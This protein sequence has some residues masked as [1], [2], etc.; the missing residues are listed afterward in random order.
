M[1]FTVLTDDTVKKRGLYA[2]HGLSLLI[3]SKGRGILFDTGQS[4]VYIKNAK[5]LGLSLDELD[6]IVLSH[7]HYDHCGGIKHLPNQKKEPEIFL[8][9]SAAAQKYAVNPDGKTH[10]EIGIPWSVKDYN[11]TLIDGCK[12]IDKD[13]SLLSG[14]KRTT[15]FE[16]PPEGFFVKD[17][18]EMTADLID[19]EQ[20]L[21]IDTGGGIAVFLGCCHPGVINCL[22]YAA[23]RFPEKEIDAVVA[24]MHL[25]G[26]DNLRL[27]MTIQGF[28]DLG[29]K[30]VYPLHCTG[31]AAVCEIKK[32]LGER[33][34]V[35]YAGDCA[36]I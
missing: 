14:V 16:K 29:V 30:K 1:K 3:E 36:E 21:V 35:I 8:Q 22:R 2:E 15:S 25:D 20:M 12:Q 19:D 32:A 24:G 5:T 11:V 31:M 33:C 17:K 34:G 27:R 28:S 4:D 13:I 26:A 23:S 10:R 6:Y 18:G 9:K 7:G